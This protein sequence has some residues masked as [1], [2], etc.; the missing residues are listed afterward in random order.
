MACRCSWHNIVWCLAKGF[1]SYCPFFEILIYLYILFACDTAGIGCI[2]VTISNSSSFTRI[3]MLV[4]NH[5]ERV[6]QNIFIIKKCFIFLR[7]V[8]WLCIHVKI[9]YYHSIV[10]TL[11]VRKVNIVTFCLVALSNLI[12]NVFYLKW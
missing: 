6:A 2:L 12:A 3:Y 9:R 7:T 10:H 1:Q 8:K 5:T 11:Y 4:L